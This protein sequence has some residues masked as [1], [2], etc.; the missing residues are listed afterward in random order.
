MSE[1][2][3]AQDL[4]ALHRRLLEG[5]RVA[6][7][8]LIEI[9]LPRLVEEMQRKFPKTDPHLISDGVTD[10][11][12][13]YC[14]KPVPFDSR[15]GVP[16]D[17]FLA[18]AGWRNIANLLRGESRRRVREAK[19]AECTLENVVELRPGTGN[20]WHDEQPD[21]KQ[22]LDKLSHLLPNE[23]DRKLFQLKAAGERRTERFAKAMGIT[24]LPIEQQ[25]REVKKAKDRI[26]KVLERRKTPPT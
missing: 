13:D 11:L 4:L 14:A 21:P 15:R 26:D 10:A 17:R 22:E 19:F 6:P 25:R 7:A 23:T 1:E 8:E 2:T 16:L 5:D 9:L 24:H 3:G 20:S 18:K 12:L